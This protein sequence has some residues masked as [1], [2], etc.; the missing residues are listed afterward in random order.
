MPRLL[1]ALCV[2]LLAE[3]NAEMALQLA[4][5]VY[6]VDHGTVVFEG[7]SNELRGDVQAATT[8]LGVG[9]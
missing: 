3:Q 4:D 6:V 7:T 5:R 9:R 2:L 1:I 8:Y